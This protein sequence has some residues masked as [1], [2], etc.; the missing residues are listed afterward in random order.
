MKKTAR[1]AYLVTR[2]NKHPTGLRKHPTIVIQFTD[3]S[4]K[5]FPIP[6]DIRK[7]PDEINVAEDT[8]KLLQRKIALN[9]FNYDDYFEQT[10]ITIGDFRDLFLSDQYDLLAENKLAPK[11]IEQR[12]CAFKAFLN[13]I[14]HH[15]SLANIGE[16]EI[17]LFSKK[18]QQQGKSNATVNDYLRSLKRAFNW[19]TPK[20]IT[21][22]VFGSYTLLPENRAPKYLTL[23]DIQRIRDYFGAKSAMWPLQAMDLSLNTGIRRQSLIRLTM[24]DI[25]K[26]EIDGD[27]YFFLNVLEKWHRKQGQT[28]RLVPLIPPALVVIKARLDYLSDPQQQRKIIE[29]RPSP[30]HYRQYYKRAESGHLFFE[31][32]RE[33]SFTQMMREAAMAL[34]IDVTWHSLRHSAATY[35]REQGVP[36][37]TRMAILGHKTESAHD[38][39]SKETIKALAKGIEHWKGV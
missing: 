10:S 16:D 24:G 34:N 18:L 35:M 33:N 14:D 13:I 2:D 36:K 1:R 5:S 29:T 7:N 3:G 38:I 26:H 31:V 32:L 8:L 21:H 19:G 15:T 39:Y 28:F 9:T 25:Q 12:E 17:K 20:Y 4:T 22:Q 11:T 6:I 30:Q 27:F 37:E 23:D